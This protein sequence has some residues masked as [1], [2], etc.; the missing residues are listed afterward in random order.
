MKLRWLV[1]VSRVDFLQA[2][3]IGAHVGMSAFSESKNGRPA[4]NI[5]LTDHGLSIDLGNEGMTIIPINV[6]KQIWLVKEVDATQPVRK[7]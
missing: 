3:T 7:A 1:K 5:T 2:I 6:C 4:N